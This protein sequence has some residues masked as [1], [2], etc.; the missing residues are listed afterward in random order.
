MATNGTY[1]LLLLLFKQKK[2]KKIVV[3][4]WYAAEMHPQVS[5]IIIPLDGKN[6][7]GRLIVFSW[8]AADCQKN[9]V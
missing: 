5:P 6:P 8:V 7:L 9:T 4:I 1:K 3:K 2:K